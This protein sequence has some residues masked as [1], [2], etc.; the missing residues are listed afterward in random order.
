M[1]KRYIIKALTLN[2]TINISQT[3]YTKQNSLSH[4]PYIIYMHVKDYT[5]TNDVGL[6]G[7]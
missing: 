2:T 7:K 5:C 3:K 6:A 1:L 4:K